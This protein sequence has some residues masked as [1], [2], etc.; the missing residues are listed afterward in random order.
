MGRTFVET[1]MGAVVLAVAGIFLVFALNQSDLGV[2]KG[3]T[4]SA[5]FA[6]V[7][8]L[9]TGSDVRI[10]GIKV[11]TV[12]S[13]TI[14]QNTYNA[15]VKLSVNPSIHLP[16]DTVASIDSDGLLGS[17]FLKLAPGH[18][19]ERIAEGGTIENTKNFESLEDTVGKVIFYA[20]D[21]GAKK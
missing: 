19:E 4:L 10:N 1:I 13:Q 12:T 17:K 3:Y 9:S 8:G 11:G 5:S 2:V 14:D 18:A 20:T 16:K 21:S 6:S 15:V 7:G